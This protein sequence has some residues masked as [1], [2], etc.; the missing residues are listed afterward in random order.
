MSNLFR[1]PVWTC[2]PLYYGCLVHIKCFVHYASYQIIIECLRWS[3]DC[4]VESW[5]FPRWSTLAVGTNLTMQCLMRGHSHTLIC[6]LNTS[7][8]GWVSCLCLH[9]TFNRLIHVRRNPNFHIV[10]PFHNSAIYL[11]RRKSK[12][13]Q[14]T[15]YDKG[16]AQCKALISCDS[17]RCRNWF[18]WQ[19]WQ[20]AGRCWT[21]GGLRWDIHETAH[22]VSFMCK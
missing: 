21:P 4:L 17:Q 12:V 15:W 19:S 22:Y 2:N 16:S 7:W 10:N 20:P 1:S 13:L 14:G 6:I 5:S 3:D 11:Y 9:S 18:Q 8:V